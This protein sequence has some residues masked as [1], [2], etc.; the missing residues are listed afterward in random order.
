[1]NARTETY[2]REY[3]GEQAPAV[4]EAQSPAEKEKAEMLRNELKQLSARQLKI[5]EVANNIYKEKNK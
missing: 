2:S 3:E 4:T 5:M 1:V